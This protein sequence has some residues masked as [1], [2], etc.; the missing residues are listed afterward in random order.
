MSCQKMEIFRT[1][2][3][4]V[5]KSSEMPPLELSLSLSASLDPRLPHSGKC[6]LKLCRG[7]EPGIFCCVTMT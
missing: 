2:C 4:R 6:A 3:K 7:G 1:V 5:S